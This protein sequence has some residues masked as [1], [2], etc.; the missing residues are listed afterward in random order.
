MS[1]SRTVIW[2]KYSFAL[3]AVLAAVSLMSLACGSEN[4][5]TSPADA[6][7]NQNLSGSTGG[8]NTGPA[9]DL[10]KATNGHDADEAPGPE[11]FV[12]E[13]VT[14]TYV[15][16]NTGQSALTH[17]SL[18]DRPLGEIDCPSHN[19]TPG[20]SMT[21][22]ARGVAVEG[23]YH[24]V[25]IVVGNTPDSR[26]VTDEDHS[27]Y[28]GISPNEPRIDLEKYT[29][30]EN[31]DEEPGPE[32]LAGE[33]VTWTYSVKNT[34][35]VELT[36]ITLTDRPV[37]PISCPRTTLAPG[38]AMRCT[39]TGVAV[40]GQYTN[41]GKVT[42]YGP[43]RSEAIDEDFSHYFGVQALA[44]SIDLEKYTNG[45]NADRP[46]GPRIPVGDPV[47]WTYSVTNTGEVLLAAIALTDDRLGD[48]TCPSTTLQPGKSMRCT[49]TGRAMEG[50]Y[51]NVGRVIG[52]GPERREAVDTDPSHYF[53]F[54]DITG[55]I[56]CSHGYWK[57]HASSWLATG[58]SQQDTVGR[59]F[60]GTIP[61]PAVATSS[62]SEALKFGGGS[63][64]EG[65]V[66]NLM[67]QAVAALLNAAH[68]DVPYP[69]TATEV[70]N[71][72][73]RALASNDRQTILRLAGEFDRDNNLGCPLD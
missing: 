18:K 66:K 28:L 43:D 34:G 33:T 45:E 49:A 72:V 32:I 67:R 38:K 23:Q 44:P 25:G 56:G 65:A 69:R 42:G 71:L 50:Q 22:K 15:I 73:D 57:N 46:T 16:T 31:A 64:V 36:N 30:G 24:N 9:I 8:T 29:N 5:P 19:L 59:V 12:G 48:V 55:Q 13:Q 21:C 10:E 51:R 35:R 20:E 61:W 58:Y 63:G 14:W 68:P 6:G 26:Q 47:T 17:I 11:I 62:L 27:H 52:F 41:L 70:I 53:G 2:N 60:A 7:G 3:V 4:S 37:G 40:V 1:G 54:E 39:A